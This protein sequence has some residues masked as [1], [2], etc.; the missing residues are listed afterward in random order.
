MIAIPRGA[1]RG[2]ERSSI[3]LDCRVESKRRTGC[4]IADARASRTGFPFSRI[5][6]DPSPLRDRNSIHDAVAW[7]RYDRVAF[8]KASEHFG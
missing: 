1:A 6:I 5:V 4:S 7:M 8:R 2:V 3:K